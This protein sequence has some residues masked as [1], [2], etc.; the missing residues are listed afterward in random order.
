MIPTQ[1][2]SHRPQPELLAPA[3][4]VES[5]C[6]ALQYG[7]DAI[8]LG[9]TRF[10]A[11]AGAENFTVDTLREIVGLAHGYS[12][13]RKIYVTVNTLILQHETSELIRLLNTLEAVNVDAVIVQDI[14]VYRLIKQYF[15]RHRLHASTQMTIHNL[16]GALM[17]AELGFS[18]VTLARELT[19]EEIQDITEKSGIETEVFVHGALCYSYSGL[20]LFSSH[21]YGRSG[22]RGQCA[23]CCRELYSGVSRDRN[24][25]F[26]SFCFS[27]K[28]LAL[29][30]F[31]PEL[32][33]AGVSAFK[34]EGRMKSPLYVAAVTNLYRKVIDKQIT[35]PEISK[36]K[37]DIHTIF[38]RPW[39]SLYIK[40]KPDVHPI[41]MEFVGH[42]GLPIGTVVAVCKDKKSYWLCFQ[43]ER[44]LEKHDGLQLDIPSGKR[45]YGF[46]VTTMRVRQKSLSRNYTYP[47]VVSPG[48]NVE[49]LLPHGHPVIPEGT[50]VYCSSSQAVKRFYKRKR[51]Q[52]GMHKQRINI[53]ITATITQ[54]MLTVTAALANN[55]Q[56]NAQFSVSGY[57]Q[58]ARTPERTVY[59]F[60]KAFERMHDTE[61]VLDKLNVDNKFHL[62]V[63]PK[64]L[65]E[66]RRQIAQIL[67]EKYKE[68][69][70]NRLNKI[71]TIQTTPD[72]V[73]ALQHSDEWSLK[74]ANPSII[75]AFERPDLQ[76]ISEVVITLPLHTQKKEFVTQIHKLTERIQKEKIRLAL[77]LIVRMH[78]KKQLYG[79]I[80]QFYTEDFNNWE[81]SNLASFYFLKNTLSNQCDIKQINIT[82]DWSIFAMNIFTIDQLVQLG[83]QQI[84]LS[85]EDCDKNLTTLLHL[86]GSKLIVMAF[87]YTPLFISETSPFTGIEKG[88]C[89]EHIKSPSAQIY[90]YHYQDSI[91]V[92]TAA[93]PF[94]LVH[95]LLALRKAGAFRF[96]VDLSWRQVSPEEALTYWQKIMKDDNIPNTYDANY[97]RT[98][99]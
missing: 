22:N 13:P 19:L 10:S 84:V 44:A 11:R 91:H 62:F 92:L 95:H 50:I 36:I 45:P 75:S 7:A 66:S 21:A 63:P 82:A 61:W 98:L 77:P 32:I 48:T 4:G 78:N 15:P 23:Y 34:I 40:G 31:V 47:V 26:S 88:Q 25:I 2:P 72:T 81:V 69:T 90:T 76:T 33:R 56:I 89:P 30:D 3:G 58:T 85:P 28:D 70:E 73:P 79:T 52:K 14:G 41:D 17:L 12:P 86:R 16:E 6:S 1:H 96:R 83:M 67:S 59:A 20:C 8:Y 80:Q 29:V 74:I 65:N 27:M 55:P 51:L 53:N 64:I 9:M 43:T 49:V 93:R 54:E 38:S 46:S 60:R 42:R 94:S 99:L 39:T 5:A 18:R 68:F 35:P 57:F 71:L 97:K 37:D 24:Q 87:Q